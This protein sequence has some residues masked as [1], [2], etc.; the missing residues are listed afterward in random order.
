[1]SSLTHAQVLLADDFKTSSKLF[2]QSIRVLGRLKY[3]N[4]VKSTGIIIL[5]DNK[6]ELEIDSSLIPKQTFIIGT[7][8]HFIG[9]IRCNLV[10]NFTGDIIV[11]QK[12]K[13]FCEIKG[14][15]NKGNLDT[16]PTPISKNSIILHL[17]IAKQINTLFNIKQYIECVKQLRLQMKQSSKS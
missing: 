4:A 7:M 14:N 1:M 11:S 6:T 17:R 13:M 15:T 9:E 3:F 16:S 5:E 8:Y 12:H 10:Q 2:D